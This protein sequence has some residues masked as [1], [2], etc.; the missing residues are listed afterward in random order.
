MPAFNLVRLGAEAVAYHPDFYGEM[1]D[2]VNAGDRSDRCAVSWVLDTPEAVAASA[3]CA[4]EPADVSWPVTSG[5][6]LLAVDAQGG[7]TT[8]RP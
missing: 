3:R 8:R 5:T 6:V 2:G 7:P 1:Q 4:I